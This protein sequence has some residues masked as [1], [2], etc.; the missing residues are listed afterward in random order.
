MLRLDTTDKEFCVVKEVLDF[1]LGLGV[2]S[3]YINDIRIYEEGFVQI[4]FSEMMPI[5][6]KDN[7]ISIVSPGDTDGKWE[8]VNMCWNKN[9]YR[10]CGCRCWVDR[11]FDRQFYD[12]K[13]SHQ[14]CNKD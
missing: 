4:I 13:K 7:K 14:F 12:P 9:C 8:S 6:I 2:N 5:Y 10:D 1:I 3:N 11:G